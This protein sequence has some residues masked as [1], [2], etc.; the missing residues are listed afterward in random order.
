MTTE[1]G[2]YQR[3]TEEHI[4]ALAKLSEKSAH[5]REQLRVVPDP[6]NLSG[7]SQSQDSLDS[8]RIRSARRDSQL[9]AASN[10]H[11]EPSPGDRLQT[12]DEETKSGDASQGLPPLFSIYGARPSDES[13]RPATLSQP[14]FFRP[15][16]GIVAAGDEESKTQQDEA[17][18]ETSSP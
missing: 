5:A 7:S 15:V 13:N 2:Q 6:S 4:N 3:E 12:L 1:L 17:K 9:S 11:S 16:V 18:D 10:E 8:G 14:Q